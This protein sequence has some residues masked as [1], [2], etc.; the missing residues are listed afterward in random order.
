[1]ITLM[2]LRHAAF[3]LAPRAPHYFHFQRDRQN[4]MECFLFC[5]YGR[6]EMHIKLA[7]CLKV[8]Q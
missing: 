3:D 6:V 4:E 5:V 8:R 7:I 2:R 1:M